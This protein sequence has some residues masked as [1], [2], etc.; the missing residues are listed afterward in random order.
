MSRN[1]DLKYDKRIQKLLDE[2]CTLDIETGNI[3]FNTY[4][5]LHI[6]IAIGGSY[7]KIPYS[8]LVWFLYYK[9]W[10]TEGL[11]VDHIDDNSLNN[12]P[13]NLQLL[14]K[15]DNNRKRKGKGTKKYGSGKYGYGIGVS[16]DK[17][18]GKYKVYR[19]I[20]GIQQGTGNAKIWLFR[21]N[22][23]EEVED[24]ISKYID[25]INSMGDI[26]TI[27]DLLGV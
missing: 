5:A 13:S 20:Q 11:E 3:K 25:E 8:H 1:K 15:L 12:K 23:K 26:N 2:Y 27:D 4:A 16:Y 21:C 14:T 19:T 22:T 18:R 9:K 6:Q 17:E 24:K 7:I 10:P